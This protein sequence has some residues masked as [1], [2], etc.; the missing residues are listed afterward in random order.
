M[1]IL[2]VK[3]FWS[4][5]TSLWYCSFCVFIDFYKFLKGL[6]SFFYYLAI[7]LVQTK[8][9]VT[10]M[11]YLYIYFLCIIQKKYNNKKCLLSLIS[12]MNMKDNIDRKRIAKRELEVIDWGWEESPVLVLYY[13]VCASGEIFFSRWK[14][15]TWNMRNWKCCRVKKL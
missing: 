1:L 11:I 3:K 6:I 13:Y 9:P 8:H 10:M 5:S 2:F 12:N 7:I 4:W 14:S 15:V